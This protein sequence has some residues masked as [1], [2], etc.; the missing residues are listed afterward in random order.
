M[1]FERISPMTNQPASK[2]RAMTAKEAGTVVD[3]AAVGFSAWSVLGPAARRATLTKAAAA[4]ES[5]KDQFVAAM[6][7]EVGATAGWAM[8][9]LMLAAAMV[10]EAAALASLWAS[11]AASHPGMRRSF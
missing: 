4:L 6:M 3:R 9:N 8:F 7:A 2:A 5:R 11:Y 1:D 10:R